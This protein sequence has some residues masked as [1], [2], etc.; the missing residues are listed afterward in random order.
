MDGATYKSVTKHAAGGVGRNIAEGI[1][2]LYGDVN[3]ISAV[4]SDHFAQVLRQLMPA[5]LQSNLIVDEK[6]AT[7]LCSV[8]FDQ[9]GDCKLILGDMDIHDSITP[10]ALLTNSELFRRAPLIVMDSNL[11]KQAMNCTLELAQRFQ[12]RMQNKIIKSLN[13]F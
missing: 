3:L 11:S 7:S 12:V 13:I 4:G 9:V 8:I 5:A 2:K 6:N 10:E 1:Y